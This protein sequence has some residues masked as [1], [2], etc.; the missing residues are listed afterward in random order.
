MQY[1]KVILLV[2]LYFF[3]F[4]LGN[5]LTFPNHKHYENISHLEIVN[6]FS[7]GTYDKIICSVTDKNN[8]ICS[9]TTIDTVLTSNI[10]QHFNNIQ[11]L[12]LNWASQD[13]LQIEDNT[14]HNLTNLKELNL[15]NCFIKSRLFKNLTSLKI[16]YIR[17]SQFDNIKQDTLFFR[18]LSNLEELWISLSNIVVIKEKL[19]EN[20]INLTALLLPENQIERIEKNAFSNLKKIAFIN[21]NK[22]NIFVVD[23]CFTD[24]PKLSILLMNNNFLKDLNW[25][26]FNDS[27]IEYLD[28]SNNKIKTLDA[29]AI[30]TYLPN[31]RLLK[32]DGNMVSGE[33]RRIFNL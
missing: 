10:M 21:L 25:G 27:L 24:L 5:I 1:K 31:L 23:G 19:F 18:S 3:K 13:L 33:L 6:K 22:N 30:R 8:A 2:F 7:S 26:D 17:Q 28:L 20:L 15:E 14:F 32:I 12:H 16:L 11:G 4:A 29:K 9:L